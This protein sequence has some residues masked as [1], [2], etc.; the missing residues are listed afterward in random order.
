[1]ARARVQ[2]GELLIKAARGS[3]RARPPTSNDGL[4]VRTRV[5]PDEHPAAP[6]EEGQE[7]AS[8]R[9]A[10]ARMQRGQLPRVV[11]ECQG[12]IHCRD[13]GRER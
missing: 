1:M 8:Q 7:Q 6:D 9:G 12:V 2:A 11:G 4:P 3:E 5:G 10:K 13:T